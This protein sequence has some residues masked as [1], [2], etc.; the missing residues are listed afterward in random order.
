MSKIKTYTFD[1][2]QA[3]TMKR[4]GLPYFA[5]EDKLLAL[6]DCIAI[7]QDYSRYFVVKTCGDDRWSMLRYTRKLSRRRLT[8]SV[9]LLNIDELS[10]V[11]FIDIN[12]SLDMHT[13]NYLEMLRAVSEINTDAIRKIRCS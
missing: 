4:V 13:N 11:K 10:K 6:Y 12:S 8:E 2:I 9:D 7:T 1:D 3:V 5:Y